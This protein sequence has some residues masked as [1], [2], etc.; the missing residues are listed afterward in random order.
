M[1]EE[2]K[3][4]LS[5]ENFV[6][7][8]SDTII[9]T[10]QTIEKTL[11]DAIEY[12]I[13]ESLKHWEQFLDVSYHHVFENY[14]KSFSLKEYM[15]NG[16]ISIHYFEIILECKIVKPTMDLVL[17]FPPYISPGDMGINYPHDFEADHR[18]TVYEKKSVKTKPKYIFK[19]SEIRIYK[20]ILCKIFESL[21]DDL[22][23]LLP[24]NFSPVGDWRQTFYNIKTGEAFFC[25][26]FREA[27]EKQPEPK[28]SF[29]KLHP[30]IKY[31]LENKAYLSGICHLCT[32]T[33]PPKK[34]NL[35][36]SFDFARTYSAY[37]FKIK[38]QNT[39]EL[40]FK[41]AEDI[42]REMVGFPLIGEGWVSETDLYKRIKNDFPE[43]E[44]IH[45]GRPD[46]LGRQEYDIWM[47]K[48][49][50]A[51]EYQGVQHYKPL[52]IWGGEEGLRK[53]Q[54]LDKK[55]KEISMKN[56]VSIVYVDE[57][58]IYSDLVENIKE[59]IKKKN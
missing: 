27:I 18:L 45:H 8:C 53:R 41:E 29:K 2:A 34:N 57:N 23:I 11:C 15:D 5:E 21:P 9:N 51:I 47:P 3:I 4:T 17:I 40:T 6:L 42:V 31:A 7:F 49:K 39:K 44:I 24:S 16:Y 26:C 56:D 55:K 35:S 13:R 1:A 52:E 10:K 20:D 30:H 46:F 54:E 38:Y 14:D 58:Y 12:S 48:Y 43:I 22:N 28:I 50:I 37:I 25:S 59:A 32:K 36:D 19:I 33:I